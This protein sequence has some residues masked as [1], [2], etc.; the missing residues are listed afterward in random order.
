MDCG[1]DPSYHPPR[2]PPYLHTSKNG[3]SLVISL[4]LSLVVGDLNVCVDPNRRGVEE[5]LS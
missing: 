3:F 4:A 2:C 5:G 1:F